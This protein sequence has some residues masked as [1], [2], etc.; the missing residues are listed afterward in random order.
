[1]NHSGGCVTRLVTWIFSVTD[2]S[3]ERDKS[4]D[5]GRDS[6][7]PVPDMDWKRLQPS[8]LSPPLNK[9]IAPVRVSP[10]TLSSPLETHCSPQHKN[11]TL[12]CPRVTFRTLK[13]PKTGTRQCSNRY[14]ESPVGL[15]ACFSGVCDRFCLSP[16][17]CCVCYVTLCCLSTT[18][19]RVH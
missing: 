12:T 17:A 1:M 9:P 8:G 3:P 14:T 6:L 16:C 18:V 2:P 11:E 5:P 10:K 15:S 7:S 4:P 13:N 19:L